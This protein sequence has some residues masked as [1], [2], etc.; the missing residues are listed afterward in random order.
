MEPFRFEAVA[1]WDERRARSF[2]EDAERNDVA[3]A[4]CLSV[5]VLLELSSGSVM[6]H[7][8][9]HT[10]LRRHHCQTKKESSKILNLLA[11]SICL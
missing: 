6:I 7:T 10:S 3:S 9:T 8:H 4:G 5:S 2:K 1:E 11:I